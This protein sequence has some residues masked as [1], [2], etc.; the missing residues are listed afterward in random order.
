[1]DRSSVARE[2][3]GL[4]FGLVGCVQNP[5]LLILSEFDG[6][7]V[8]VSILPWD[9]LN[10]DAF[11][12]FIQVRRSICVF[13]FWSYTFS[14]NF[15]LQCCTSSIPFS[16]W[17]GNGMLVPNAFDRV[18]SCYATERSGVFLKTTKII[19]H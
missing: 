14:E 12:Y 1:V 11:R 3:I 5:S 6:N 7:N 18:A 9:G 17:F 4:L 19:C 10:D 16:R 15:S 13:S 2:I 8:V